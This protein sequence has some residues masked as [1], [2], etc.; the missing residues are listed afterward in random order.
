MAMK[1]KL[2]EEHDVH[3]RL[4]ESARKS[5]TQDQEKYHVIQIMISLFR[6]TCKKHY[7]IPSSVAYYK[8]NMYVINLGTHNFHNDN[9]NMYVWD[10]TFAPRGAQEIVLCILKHVC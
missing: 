1:N 2:R 9:V 6:S 7:R 8:H 3:L 10:K 5:L 4:A